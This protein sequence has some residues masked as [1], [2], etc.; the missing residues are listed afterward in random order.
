MWLRNKCEPHFAIISNG[1]AQFTVALAVQLEVTL[2]SRI[3]GSLTT[4][5]PSSCGR[6]RDLKEKTN[7][8]KEL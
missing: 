5:I 8:P 2:F 6:N 4:Y 7:R 3:S 1:T